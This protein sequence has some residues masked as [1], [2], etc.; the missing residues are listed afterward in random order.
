[1]RFNNNPFILKALRKA[2]MHRSKLKNIYNKYRTEDNSANYRKQRNFC[3][4]LLRKNKTEYFQKLVVK[5]L[6]EN[7]KLWKTIKPL[8]GTKV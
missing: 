3:V 2:I 1:M 4:N 6:S 5:D 7:R 8:F